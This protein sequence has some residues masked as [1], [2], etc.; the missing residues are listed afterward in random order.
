ME[1]RSCMKADKNERF[2]RILLEG[3]AFGEVRMLY[4]D[5]ETGVTYLFIKSGYGAGLTPLLDSEGK[6]VI[7]R[8]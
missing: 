5:K 8:L 7:T 6:P 3:S 1:R 2:V 4:V